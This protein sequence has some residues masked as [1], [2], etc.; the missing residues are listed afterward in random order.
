MTDA[1]RH[2][3]KG[4][5][6]PL[7]ISFTTPADFPISALADFLG[8]PFGAAST[9]SR[10]AL[11]ALANLGCPHRACKGPVGRKNRILRILNNQHF[12]SALCNLWKTSAQAPSTLRT[13]DASGTPFESR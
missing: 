8:R 12:H 10:C 11:G 1:R 6:E 9:Y 2:R 4:F 5:A 7:A 13:S 3:S